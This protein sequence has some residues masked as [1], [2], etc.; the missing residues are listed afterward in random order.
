MAYGMQ[1]ENQRLG[2][3]DSGISRSN[4]LLKQIADN[5][6][7]WVESLLKPTEVTQED[8]DLSKAGAYQNKW[9]EPIRR[10]QDVIDR[11]RAMNPD[12]GPHKGFAQSVGVNTEDENQLYITA[13]AFKKNYMNNPDQYPELV[14]EFGKPG[15]INAAKDSLAAKGGQEKWMAIAM[16]R[17]RKQD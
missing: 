12:L 10:V 3:I 4:S 17:F 8:L 5:T 9:D 15:I 1:Q 7:S 11:H 16:E 6:K 13:A 2:R 14:E